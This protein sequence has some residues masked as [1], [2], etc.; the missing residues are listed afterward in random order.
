MEFRVL[1]Y[2][3]T[4]AKERN[5]TRAATLLH[6]TQPTL[7]RQLMNLEEELGMKLLIRSNRNV[8]LTDEG[9]LLCKRAEEIIEL[10]NKTEKELR[11]QNHLV[12]GEIAIG[13][14]EL[15]AA[16]ILPKLFE[17]FNK[18]YPRIHYEL[19]TG[20]ADQIKEKID[21]GL[22]DIGLLLEPVNIEKYDFIRLDI[23]E[24]WVVLMKP[25]DPLI[26]KEHVTV[27]D[28]KELPII[29]VK[30]PIIQ[31]EIASWFGDYFEK[32]NVFATSNMST[33]AALLVENGLGYALVL[34]GSVAIYDKKRICYRPLY[35]ELTSTSVLAWK[36]HQVFS[37][38]TKK[39]L[40][41]LK[42]S[43]NMSGKREEI[44]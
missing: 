7:S 29:M 18:K 32:L 43:L 1:Q 10:I 8:T 9:T 13:S 12:S 20:N 38:A 23:K 39:F 14:G 33:N 16:D 6:I 22:L 34:E 4:V 11:E 42:S 40:E 35:P 28:I 17:R 30:R 24:R 31:N 2:F 5:I 36:K 25:D 27:E 15:S 44:Y 41:F 21:I 37:F 3:L 26:E 19:Y